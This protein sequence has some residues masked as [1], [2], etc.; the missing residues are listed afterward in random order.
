MSTI[1][2]I[3]YMVKKRRMYKNFSLNGFLSG[4]LSCKRD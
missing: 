4:S 3:S 1:G 2:F